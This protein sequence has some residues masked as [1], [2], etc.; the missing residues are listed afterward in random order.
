MFII[1][2]INYEDKSTIEEIFPKNITRKNHVKIVF[3]FDY[4]LLI[5]VMD[6]DTNL[7]W[8]KKI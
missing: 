5:F 6:N 1:P 3:N 4:L 8:K 7:F 2:L